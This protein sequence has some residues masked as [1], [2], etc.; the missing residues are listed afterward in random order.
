MKKMHTY[1]L[2]LSGLLLTFPAFAQDIDKQEVEPFK[3]VKIFGCLS[4]ELVEGDKEIVEIELKSKRVYKEDIKISISKRVLKV[5]L[6][7]EGGIFSKRNCD[8]TKAHIKISYK[9]LRKIQTSG[10]AE[11]KIKS[12]VKGETFEAEVNTGSTLKMEAEVGQIWLETHTGGEL[13][14]AGKADI[15]EVKVHT[16]GVLRAYDFICKEAYAKANTGGVAQLFV[17]SLIEA[18]ASLG[19]TIALKGNPERQIIN[20]ALGGS[21]EVWR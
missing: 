4:V 6:R 3:E 10:G 11:V 8:G 19:G 17:T 12:M 15:Q 18:S 13:R 1:F 20:T 14:I 5:S 21:M 2:V 9:T 7:Y 16:G